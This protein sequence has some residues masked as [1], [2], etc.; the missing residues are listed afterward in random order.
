MKNKYSTIRLLL[1]ICIICGIVGPILDIYNTPTRIFPAI[2][3]MNYDLQSILWSSITTVILFCLAYMLIDRYNLKKINN[4]K[5]C[6]HAFLEIVY[7][8]CLENIRQMDQKDVR[9]LVLKKVD[10]NETLSATHPF[11]RFKNEPFQN[12]KVLYEFLNDGNLEVNVYRNYLRAK[13]Y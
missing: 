4:Q 6:A 10:L 7:E 12:E 3:S 1:Y 8:Q 5:E 11:M 13:K 9:T 2:K